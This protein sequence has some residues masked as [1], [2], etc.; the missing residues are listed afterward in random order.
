MQS[1]AKTCSMGF[2]EVD[3]T[4]VAIGDSGHARA[5]FRVPPTHIPRLTITETYEILQKRF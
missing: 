4:Y 1:L 3:E 5:G 2:V